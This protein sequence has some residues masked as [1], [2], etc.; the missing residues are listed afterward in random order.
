MLD[1]ETQKTVMELVSV[2]PSSLIS[3][4]TDIDL[5]TACSNSILYINKHGL[6][7]WRW[8]AYTMAIG[9]DTYNRDTNT[10]DVSESKLKQIIR[11][12]LMLK[13]Q[14]PALT[15]FMY[16]LGSCV[17]ELPSDVA[18]KELESMTSQD[19]MRLTQRTI[20]VLD[21]LCPQKKHCDLSGQR[22]M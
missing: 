4:L 20:A 10:H 22:F 19:I 21:F 1:R 9:T 7:A 5:V 18:R 14:L 3:H 8:K 13:K 6:I 17:C 12:H 11:R 16:L 15:F 2:L